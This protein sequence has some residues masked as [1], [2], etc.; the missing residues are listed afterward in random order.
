MAKKNGQLQGQRASNK[1]R[2][3]AHVPQPGFDR[4]AMNSPAAALPSRED[5]ARRA[6][7]IFRSRGAVHGR[8]LEDWLA[9]ERELQGQQ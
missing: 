5:V 4:A 8:D 3:T 9:A 2:G 6:Y 1:Q 7:E